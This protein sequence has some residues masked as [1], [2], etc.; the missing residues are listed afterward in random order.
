MQNFLKKTFQSW[1]EFQKEFIQ[2]CDTY[3]QPINIRS[4]ETLKKFEGMFPQ[5][6][7]K[8][9]YQRVIYKCVHS[10]DVRRTK[11]DGSRPNQNTACISCPFRFT[12]KYDFEV[13]QLFI[14][15]EYNLEHNHDIGGEK[16]NDYPF[17]KKRKLTE[18]PQAIDTA[19]MLIEAK[20]TNF[21]TRQLIQET[22]GNYCVNY[23]S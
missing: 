22:Y 10:E 5:M 1:D 6:V 17:V 14:H 3:H 18:M 11:T 13:K 2:V 23:V 21:E 16:Y 7:A 12:V 4:S 9:R 19:K 8:F 20:A 15:P